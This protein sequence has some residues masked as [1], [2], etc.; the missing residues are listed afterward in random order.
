MRIETA[1]DFVDVL[2]TLGFDYAF[3]PYS[4]ICSEFD[5]AH[6]PEIRRDNL[7]RVLYAALN[8]GVSSLWIARDLGYRGGRRTGL[9]LTDELHLAAHAELMGT[10]PLKRA[11]KGTPQGERTAK[12]IWSILESVRQP[13]FLWNVFPLH[14]YESNDRM[15]N[16]AHTRKEAESC[17]FLLDWLIDRLAP[18]QII[19]I[20]RDAQLAL[21]TLDIDALAVRHPSYGGQTEFLASM[22]SYYQLRDARISQAQL[23]L[24]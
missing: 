12:V 9:A 2:A 13:I 5:L 4:E 6:A 17:R 19:A 3:N 14:P 23:S 10:R 20:G 21:S 22:R 7:L 8:Q 18:A 11:T 1:G 15:S 24:L 16:R